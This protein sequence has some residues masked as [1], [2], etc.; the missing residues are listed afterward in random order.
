MRYLESSVSIAYA[1]TAVLTTAE[2]KAHL[3]VTNTAEDSLIDAYVLAA[4]R[5]LEERYQLVLIDAPVT[6]IFTRTPG[7]YSATSQLFL[8]PFDGVTAENSFFSLSIGNA[9]TLTSVT[10][11]TVDDTATF[12]AMSTT[13]VLDPGFNRPRV[14][15]PN[16]WEFGSIS[17]F[18]IKVIYRAGWAN[19]AAV[20]DIIKVV[21]RLMVA[22]M[23]ENRIDSPREMTNITEVLMRPY[24]TM[25]GI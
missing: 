10:A 15:G 3:R 21:V 8:Y 5:F 6:E 17:P 7:G 4:Q 22:D 19:A 18:Q 16:G 2:A 12:T 23:Y 1:A 11:N 14:Y 13:K 24:A 20:P 9:T 25:A